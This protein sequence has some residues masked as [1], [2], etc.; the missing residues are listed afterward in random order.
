MRSVFI[1]ILQQW[2]LELYNDV[3]VLCKETR[4]LCFR[5]ILVSNPNIYI[6]IIST[7]TLTKKT[8][9]LTET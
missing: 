8:F 2:G 4:L 6:H 5:A 3:S 7:I 9:D 1:Y